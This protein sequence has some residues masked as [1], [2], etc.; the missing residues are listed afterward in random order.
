MHGSNSHI[1][2]GADVVGVAGAQ[3][4]IRLHGICVDALPNLYLVTEAALGGTLEALLS[5]D[6]PQFPRCDPSI[7][8]VPHSGLAQ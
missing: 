7:C 8:P 5:S 3:G 4:V 6:G 2:P 1:S